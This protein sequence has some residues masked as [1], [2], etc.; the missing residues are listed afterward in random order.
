M[1]MI[2]VNATATLSH[3][4]RPPFDDCARRWLVAAVRLEQEPA[5]ARFA[6]V[7]RAPLNERMSSA[8]RIADSAAR[9][10]PAKT[11]HT[12]R[13][14]SAIGSVVNV[15]VRRPNSTH[16]SCG[17]VQGD[18]VKDRGRLRSRRGDATSR[19]VRVRPA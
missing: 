14:S 9:K 4:L 6:D 7:A 17:D 11:S 2:E 13:R 8:S 15:R 5:D 19:R 3:V 10:R 1:R 18:I 12:L 16:S